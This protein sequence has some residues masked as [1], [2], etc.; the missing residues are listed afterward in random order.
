MVIEPLKPFCADRVLFLPGRYD[1][2]SFKVEMWRS[3]SL[4]TKHSGKLKNKNK[5]KDS[6]ASVP[7]TGRAR[8]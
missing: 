7:E 6:A 8:K 2:K 3:P 1:D 5:D 4:R